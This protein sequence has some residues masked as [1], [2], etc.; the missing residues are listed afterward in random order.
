MR[1]S[2][3]LPTYIVI[4][5]IAVGVA[6]LAVRHHVVTEQT[7]I[8]FGAFIPAVILHEVSHGV[9]ALWCG[10]DTAKRA[11]RLTLNPI[12]H[13]DP[14][15]SVVLPLILAVTGAPIF[16]WAKP[17]PVSIDRLRHPRN[18]AVLVG[19]AGPATNIILAALAGLAFHEL[20][21][22]VWTPAPV[23][24]LFGCSY[25]PSTFALVEQILFWFG[26]VNIVL[27]AFNMIPIPPLDGSSL[28]ERLIPTSALPGYYRMRMGFLVVVLV[29]VLFDQGLLS[30]VLGDVENWYFSLVI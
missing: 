25:D 21:V 22:H 13:I 3:Q 15:G 17:V 4:A 14:I 12:K 2:Q 27:A 9:V 7:L 29:L 6:V 24:N 5:A 10:D 16:G 20:A 30:R 11:G 18:D 19:L 8:F 26:I 23:C 28:V 1:S